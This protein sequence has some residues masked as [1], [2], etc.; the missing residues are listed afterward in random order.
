M[1]EVQH[2]SDMYM[3]HGIIEALSG[4]GVVMMDHHRAGKCMH[5][6]TT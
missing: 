4:I 5:P 2:D 6:M 1:S 3:Y